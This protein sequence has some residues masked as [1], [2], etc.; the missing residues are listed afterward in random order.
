[1]ELHGG[2]PQERDAGVVN[3]REVGGVLVA[4][5]LPKR[6]TN[7][8]PGVLLACVKEQNV[9][10]NGRNVYSGGELLGVLP[11]RFR[12]SVVRR[13]MLIIMTDKGDWTAVYREKDKKWFTSGGSEVLPE[14]GIDVTAT[15]TISATSKGF[16]MND[17]K[18]HWG[19]PISED[20]RRV[21]T[22]SVTAAYDEAANRAEE[23]GLHAQPVVVWYDL[24]GHD[25]RVLMRSAPKVVCAESGFQGKE[26]ISMT[27][28]R[29]GGVYNVV[30]G[31]TV[32]LDAYGVN[33]R[34]QGSKL[35]AER[36]ATAEIY[37]SRA[38][39][40]I[41]RKGQAAVTF[42]A[43]NAT[44]GTLHVRLPLKSGATN[45]AKSVAENQKLWQEKPVAVIANPFGEGDRTVRIGPAEGENVEELLTRKEEVKDELQSMLNLPHRFTATCVTVTSDMVVWGGI[46]LIP[47]DPSGAEWLAMTRSPHSWTAVTAITMR[48]SSG[49]EEV[50]T[51]RCEGKTGCP[52]TLSPIVAYP[53]PGVVSISIEVI[54]GDG[55]RRG[56]TLPLTPTGSSRMSMYT[57]PG[58]VPIELTEK[59]SRLEVRSE[60]YGSEVTGSGD[61]AFCDAD[62]P[63]KVLSTT[64]IIEGNVT[65]IADATRASRSLDLGRR[66]IIV[67]AD[68]GIYALGM[69][70][71]KGISVMT[72][73][74][75]RG[76]KSAAHTMWTPYG[77]LALAGGCLVSIDGPNVKTMVYGIDATA[78]GWSGRHGEVWCSMKDGSSA[79][80]NAEGRW[81]VREGVEGVERWM[82]HNGRLY[83][84]GPGYTFEPDEEIAGPVP[85]KWWRRALISGLRGQRV[86]HA[87]VVM[88]ADNWTGKV[89]LS[90]GNQPL[91]ELEM[92]GQVSTPIHVTPF[93]T[94]WRD[95]I[96]EVSGVM[97]AGG[98][99]ERVECLMH[100]A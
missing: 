26:R 84:C 58:L 10:L 93:G 97:D 92:S 96:V 13:N 16:T 98:S 71:T 47:G 67:M 79:T 37:M 53:H 44:S 21:M 88:K 64:R 50:I 86:K 31:G 11:A 73:L 66:H 4:A 87:V 25:G 19:G 81:C 24:K 80:V 51:R 90:T 41:N 14:V 6:V 59:Y 46:Q 33:V 27:V 2:G 85:V 40:P 76:V 43:S 55:V 3:M 12:C 45:I 72:Q 9:Y 62:N 38:I 75:C 22:E 7:S 99:V 32:A 54:R 49:G 82:M 17:G 78:I 39:D 15:T 100:N 36:V 52:Q 8:M 94:A 20:D 61:I 1:M 77:V 69:N 35:G 74:D 63:L 42:G 28:G 34:L 89:K 23:L 68:S 5:G 56:V 65:A 60:E 83:G 57:S 29:S 48:N 18:S 30:S 70:P 91:V 95:V